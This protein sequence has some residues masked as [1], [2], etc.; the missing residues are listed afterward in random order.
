[1]NTDIFSVDY[2]KEALRIHI[3]KNKDAVKPIHAANSYYRSIVASVIYDTR[4]KKMDLILRL[5]NLDQA[6][7]EIKAEIREKASSG[8]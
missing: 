6:Y 3:E 2:F 5:R 1:M 8:Q 7:N 4:H